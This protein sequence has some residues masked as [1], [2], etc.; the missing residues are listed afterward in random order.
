MHLKEKISFQ[1][2]RLKIKR[3][4]LQRGQTL[5]QIEELAKSRVKARRD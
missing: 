4:E 3:V 1:N 5:T 2:P